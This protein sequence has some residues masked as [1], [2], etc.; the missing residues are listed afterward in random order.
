[1]AVVVIAGRTNVGKSTLFNRLIGKRKA[2]TEKVEGVTRDSIKGLVIHDETA[3]TLYDTCG[4]FETT[5]D[6]ILS[7]MKNKAFETFQ[8]ADL[9]LFVVDGRNGIT[10]DDEYIAAQLR[11]LGKKIILVINKAENISAVEKNISDILR[12]GFDD[13]V[14]VS[15]QHG[16][17]IDE[18]LEKIL[19]IL[20][21]EGVTFEKFSEDSPPAIAI[22]GKPNVGKSSLFNALIGQERSTVTPI[23]GT[24]RDSIDETILISGKKFTFVDTAGMRRK[25]RIQ[26]KT[27]EYFS[28]SRTI[29]AIESAD[30]VL[31]I[32]DATEGITQQDKKIADLILSNGKAMVCV[33]NKFDLSNI[34]KKDHEAMYLNEMPFASFCRLIFTSA[35]KKTGLKQLTDAILEAYESYSRKIQ[36]EQL[37]RLVSQLSLLSPNL[38]R[39]DLKIYSIRQIKTKPPKFLVQVNK[40]ELT[41]EGIEKTLQRLLRERVD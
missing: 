15:A 41:N 39:G 24:T 30:I 35:T 10:S 34:S 27:V 4:I 20:K 31:L 6:L 12:L 1:M 18:L 26:R 37:S 36:Q 21:A 2:I 23:P 38:S 8:Q 29:D 13:Y 25:S 11:K 16:N 40:K 17:N 3:F 32:M 22:V 14:L 7:A 19:K 33:M 28:V 9:I 5:N